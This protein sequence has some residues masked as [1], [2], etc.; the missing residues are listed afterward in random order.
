MNQTIRFPSWIKSII[1]AKYDSKSNV[2]CNTKVHRIQ[3][4]IHSYKK[5]PD[6]LSRDDTGMTTPEDDSKLF[7]LVYQV[8]SM[9]IADDIFPDGK[10]I[11]L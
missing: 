7:T 3:S 9:I 8:H 5:K 11:Y 6:G 4:Y 10:S 1:E 2:Q